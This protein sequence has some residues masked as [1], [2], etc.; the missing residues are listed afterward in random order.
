MDMEKN[1]RKVKEE[2]KEDGHE[3]IDAMDKE[4]E[5]YVIDEEWLNDKGEK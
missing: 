5:G 3:V 1:M 4:N 2:D